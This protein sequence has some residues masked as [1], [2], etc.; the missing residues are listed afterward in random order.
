[1]TPF[2]DYGIH[3]YLDLVIS[4][5]TILLVYVNYTLIRKTM[6]E[7][8]RRFEEKMDRLEKLERL[9]AAREFAA[10]L[11][12]KRYN[13]VSAKEEHLDRVLRELSEKNKRE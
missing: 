12:R 6:A 7:N 13:A 11:A 5:L 8:K 3:E 10:E 1:M 2:M 4:A 9:E